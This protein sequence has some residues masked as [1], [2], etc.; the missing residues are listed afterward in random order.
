MKNEF[1]NDINW[2]V[3]NPSSSRFKSISLVIISLEVTIAPSLPFFLSTISDDNSPGL[4]A[5]PNLTSITNLVSCSLVSK[6]KIWLALVA[7]ISA[8]SRNKLWVSIQSSRVCD[9][10][11]LKFCVYDLPLITTFNT[12]PIS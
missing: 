2:P 12:L 7:L 9:I 11:V 5:L 10:D 3:A 4:K 1:A 8:S 6:Y